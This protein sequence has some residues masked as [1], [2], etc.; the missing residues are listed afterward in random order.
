MPD[1][2]RFA[3]D[4]ILGEPLAPAHQRITGETGGWTSAVMRS[5]PRGTSKIEHGEQTIRLV[6]QFPAVG[7]AVFTAIDFPGQC[8]D[9]VLVG[10]L[11]Q[12]VLVPEEYGGMDG[13]LAGHE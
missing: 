11:V 5:G 9:V 6:E 1:L 8:H 10:E 4:R 12:A 3:I 13:V 7:Q 2:I